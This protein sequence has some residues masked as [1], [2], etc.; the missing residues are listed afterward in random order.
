MAVLDKRR[1]RVKLRIVMISITI[2]LLTLAVAATAQVQPSFSCS[3][4]TM[5]DEKV[6]CSDPLLARMDA[7]IDRAYRSY[8]PPF[9]AR[10]DVA[11]DLLADR[12]GCRDDRACIAGIMLEMLSVYSYDNDQNPSPE[13]WIEPYVL[14]LAGNKAATLAG[15]GLPLSTEMPNRPGQCVHTRIRAVTTRFG[16]PVEYENA[17]QGTAIQY[18]NGAYGVSYGREGLYGVEAGHDIILCLVSI[19]RDCPS[20]DD[21]GRMYLGY[22]LQG[23]LQWLLPDSQHRCGGA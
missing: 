21:R 15:A 3:R 22:D 19:P 1:N 13:P 5:P 8:D 10:K 23:S 17:D 7:A 14:G 16:E 2:P 6:I 11:R 12:V 4:A 20:G 18:E 9:R